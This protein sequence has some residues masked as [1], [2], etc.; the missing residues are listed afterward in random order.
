MKIK[1]FTF[2]FTF[3]IFLLSISL[4][5]QTDQVIQSIEIG[6]FTIHKIQVSEFQIPSSILQTLGQDQMPEFDAALDSIYG[7][8]NT[9]LIKT[10][11]QNIL[12]DAGL[13]INE[14]E[15]SP[16]MQQLSILGVAANQIDK[17]LITHFHFDHI[18]GL[19]D[20]EGN[21]VFPNATLYVSQDESDYWQSDSSILL[22]KH[23]SWAHTL[24]QTLKPYIESNHY[25]IFQANEVLADGIKAIPAFGHTP[26]HTIFSFT[27]G[28]QELWCIGDLLHLGAIQF[29]HPRL[30]VSFDTDPQMA[31]DSRDECFKRAAKSDV[32]LT[33]SHH[34]D[35]FKIKSMEDKFVAKSVSTK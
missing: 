35:F 5:G 27:S 7:P 34:Y 32:V 31:V 20:S 14:K 17:I 2:I 3:L 16:L 4:K 29:E 24:K 33:A 9:Y 19:I 12:V 30:G 1:Q 13:R 25:Q 8:L 15:P 6:D 10:P 28:S 22:K 23:L 21:K 26:G 18:S 11:N